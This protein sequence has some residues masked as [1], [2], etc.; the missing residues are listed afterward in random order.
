MR[1]DGQDVRAGGPATA[2]VKSDNRLTASTL[3]NNSAKTSKQTQKD[4]VTQ[5]AWYRWVC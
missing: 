1:T 4:Q 5:K 2:T 3:A